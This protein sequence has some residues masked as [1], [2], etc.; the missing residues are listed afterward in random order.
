MSKIKHSHIPIEIAFIYHCYVDFSGKQSTVYTGHF[1]TIYEIEAI[2]KILLDLSS[3]AKMLTHNPC[4]VW[5]KVDSCYQVKL[6]A[7]N[8]MT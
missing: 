8:F 2:V 4:E 5:R 1:D 6:L 3:E 7:L